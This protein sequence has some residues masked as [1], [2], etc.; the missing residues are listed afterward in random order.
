MT[1][2]LLA[3]PNTTILWSQIRFKLLQ[4]VC[5]RSKKKKWFTSLRI[6]FL[7]QGTT[8]VFLTWPHYVSTPA[9]SEG[10]RGLNIHG[11][12]GRW[13]TLKTQ[14][15]SIPLALL[16]MAP[17]KASSRQRL[18]NLGQYAVKV[19]LGGILS[20]FSKHS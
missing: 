3:I 2:R 1:I 20:H 9:T 11:G 6:I 12:E 4:K 10:Q 8:F 5:D 13:D 16:G 18:Q 14:E 17:R 19:N 15:A 7:F